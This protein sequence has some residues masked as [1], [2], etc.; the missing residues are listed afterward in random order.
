M[1][2]TQGSGAELCLCSPLS[3]NVHKLAGPYYFAYVL[4]FTNRVRGTENSQVL[5]ISTTKNEAS[6][7]FSQVF[8][9]HLQIFSN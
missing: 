3:G 8:W 9:D 7:T 6:S 5:K 2:K 1:R 4:I